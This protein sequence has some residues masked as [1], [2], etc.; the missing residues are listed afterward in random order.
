MATHQEMPP[1]HLLKI[2]TPEL[3]T[4]LQKDP[5]RRA[6]VKDFTQKVLRDPAFLARVETAFKELEP[7][8]GHTKF[9]SVDLKS[10]GWEEAARL[11][12]AKQAAAALAGAAAAVV[13]CCCVPA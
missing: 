4:W 12:T 13:A 5:D 6:F 1:L 8:L 7:A 2:V 11:P 9:P 3:I 10:F